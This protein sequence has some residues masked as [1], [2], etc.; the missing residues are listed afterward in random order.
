MNTLRALFCFL[1][2]ALF[3]TAFSLEEHPFAE[4]MPRKCVKNPD[5]SYQTPSE[6]KELPQKKST[7]LLIQRGLWPQFCLK[8]LMEDPASC[9]SWVDDGKGNMCLEFIAEGN[10]VAF[11]D[12]DLI[13]EI[14]PEIALIPENR[15]A[16]CDYAGAKH[17]SNL[18][19]A[20][21]TMRKKMVMK[22]LMFDL[23]SYIDALVLGGGGLTWRSLLK[24]ILQ[25]P[26]SGNFARPQ[27]A[28][29]A[30]LIG[31]IKPILVF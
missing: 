4:N 11:F 15:K 27:R 12:P 6:K 19:D 23:V 14:L 17:V 31:T 7:L 9:S 22:V 1:F 2:L 20:Q 29:V 21:W 26:L 8:H 30:I 5:F 28:V 13:G 10:A 24:V 25:L 3:S 18:C 16:R